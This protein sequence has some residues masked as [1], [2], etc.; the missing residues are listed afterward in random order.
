MEQVF[1]LASITAVTQFAKFIYK[2]NYEGAVKIAAA[3]AVG[4]LSSL[5][6]DI[7]LVQGI[8]AGLSAAGVYTVA[9]KV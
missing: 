9:Q 3:V 5:L 1:I 8:I 6:F 4:A 2:R 7:T